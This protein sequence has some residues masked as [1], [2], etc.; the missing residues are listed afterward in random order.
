MNLDELRQLR[1]QIT[2]N[3]ADVSD[4]QIQDAV[5]AIRAQVAEAREQDATPDLVA[6]LEE[7]ADIRGAIVGERDARVQAAAANSEK[8]REL[9]DSLDIADPPAPTEP[10]PAAED[11]TEVVAQDAAAPVEVAEPALA[12][13]AE[14]FAAALVASFDKLT[15]ARQQHPANGDGGAKPEGRVAKNLGSHT[16]TQ[17]AGNREAVTVKV[18]ASGSVGQYQH[19]QELP[20]KLDLGRAMSDRLRGAAARGGRGERLY[21]AN[22]ISEFPESRTLRTDDLDGNYSK[23]EQALTPGALV[24]AGGLCAPL[25]VLYDVPMIGSAARPLRDALARFTVERGGIQYRPGTSAA[26]AVNGAGVWTTTDDANV[27]ESGATSKGCYVV[28]CPAVDEAVIQAI[29]SCLEFSNITARF[30]PETT[31]NNVQQGLIAHARLAENELFKAM[32][33]ESKLLYSAKLVSAT[34]DILVALDKSIA[35]YRNRHRLDDSLALMFVLPAWVRQLLRAD[36]ARQMAAGDWPEALAVSDQLMDGWFTRRGVSPVW[37]LDGS[38]AS[39]TVGGQ[40][41]PRQ[42]YDV[43][44]AGSAVPAFPTKIDSLLF[45]P[46]SF[47]F[48][49]G[50]SLDLGVVR[51]SDL[52]SN[53]RYR[54]FSETFEGVAMRGVEP[55]RLLMEVLPTGAGVGN[56]DAT[57]VTS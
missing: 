38:T 10:E 18:R 55:L 21:V 27:G 54:Q 33:A 5:A 42:T 39:E 24:A 23:I 36:L 30:D 48:L 44:A 8:A 2:N 20:S 6:Q 13:S 12:A 40:S 56:I 16:A 51:D 35:Y 29:Y 26:A 52:N 47:L 15:S 37:W 7:L 14:A 31:A 49:D 45:T 43:V 28:D 17:P 4:E 1:E 25:E 9:L 22:V 53:N 19:G 46:D 32:A 57:G 41:I 11:I 3:A 34:R 50:G